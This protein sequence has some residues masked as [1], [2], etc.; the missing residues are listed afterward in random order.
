MFILACMFLGNSNF[1]GAEE[2]GWGGL[3]LCIWMLC[4]ICAFSGKVVR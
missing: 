1:L 4:T 2:G 3:A